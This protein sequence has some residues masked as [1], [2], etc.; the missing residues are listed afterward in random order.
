LADI[1]RSLFMGNLH[2]EMKRSDILKQRETDRVLRDFRKELLCVFW[3]IPVLKAIWKRELK[4]YFETPV[5]YI[6]L[7][8]FLTISSVLF[9]GSILRQ[10]SGDLP[11]FIGQMSYLWMLLSPVLTMRL[12]AE[13]KQKRTDQL[14]LTCPVSPAEIV[15]GKF[16]A[17]ASMLGLTAMMTLMYVIV[18][19]IYGTVYPVELGVNYLGFL[20]QG[21]AFTAMDLYLSGCAGTPI[22]AAILGFGANFLIWVLD[23]LENQVQIGWLS[24][25]MK[26]LSLYRRNEPFLMGQLSWANAVFEIS[27]IV[28]FLALTVHRL[29]SQRM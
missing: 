16:L 1:Q 14:L 25:T 20:L 9:F 23:L 8:V 10:H 26:F 12:L 13:E 17:A 2:A 6:F 22:V 15:L 18:V 4:S 29:D 28:F 7:G 21:C 3:E 11:T 19:A 24:D 5:G 27:F